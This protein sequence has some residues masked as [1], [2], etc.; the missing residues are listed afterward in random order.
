MVTKLEDCF[1]SEMVFEETDSLRLEYRVKTK[2]IWTFVAE[3]KEMTVFKNGI[4]RE[5]SIYRR[6]DGK[7]KINKRQRAQN[8]KYVITAGA[9]SSEV[10]SYPITYDML[11][12]YSKEPV[13]I[14]K[15]FSG[16]FESTLNIEKIGDHKY[17]VSLPDNSYN[18]YFYRDG[19]LNEIEVHHTLYSA[20]IILA[21]K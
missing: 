21:A 16:N 3:A 7:E 14:R 4:L 17:K 19:I 20:K 1:F 9:N 18:Y 5:S 11:N 8:G 13:N 6:L 2:F 12:L 15:V 10:K